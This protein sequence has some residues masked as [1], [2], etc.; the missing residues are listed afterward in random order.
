[1]VPVLYNGSPP[2]NF[3]FLVS[4]KEYLPPLES[5]PVMYST[6]KEETRS[7]DGDDLQSGELTLSDTRDVLLE[8]LNEILQ[9]YVIRLKSVISTGRFVCLMAHSHARIPAWRRGPVST[10]GPVCVQ[11]DYYFIV[12]L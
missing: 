7:T 4:T 1:M 6:W 3:W 2:L 5:L 9:K 12:Q 8:Q 10:M 11:C